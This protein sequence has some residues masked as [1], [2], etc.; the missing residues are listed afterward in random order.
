MTKQKMTVLD[1]IDMVNW[2]PL[3]QAALAL[4]YASTG[5]LRALCREGTIPEAK[6]LGS[7]WLIPRKWVMAKQLENPTGQGAR[8]SSRR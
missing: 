1:Q 8:G 5:Y 2:I 7:Q 6:K 3:S 4:G